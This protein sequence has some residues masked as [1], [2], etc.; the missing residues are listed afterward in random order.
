MAD[1]SKIRKGGT[2]YNLKDSAARASIDAQT[3]VFHMNGNVDY[4]VSGIVSHSV[5]KNFLSNGGIGVKTDDILIST[6]GTVCKVTAV[7]GN[8]VNYNPIGTIVGQSGG[9]GATSWNDLTDKPFGEAVNV[10]LFAV[11]E[12]M[13]SVS[14]PLGDDRYG[15]LCV[16]DTTPEICSLEAGKEYTVTLNGHT[17]TEIAKHFSGE[18]GS[19]GIFYIGD[20]EATLNEDWAN[21]RYLFAFVQNY[22]NGEITDQYLVWA[23]HTGTETE[24]TECVISQGV[25]KLDEKYFPD[26]IARVSD[27]E[28]MIE[29]AIG[30]IPDASEVAY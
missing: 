16:F 26:T 2:D 24:L 6:N 29:E 23:A 30:A 13:E 18:E 25:T 27:V 21:V 22:V 5:A 3:R 14:D 12:L 15:V 4:P 1:L 9:G 8:K 10:D 11:A 7:S 20:L 28:R 17:Y 19:P